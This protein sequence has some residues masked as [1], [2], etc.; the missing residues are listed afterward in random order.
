[1]NYNNI[2]TKTIGLRIPIEVHKQAKSMAS[3]MEISLTEFIDCAIRDYI[4]TCKMG[5]EA[6][7][8]EGVA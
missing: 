6:L 8:R 4:E 2:E 3:K 7:K 5:C 1:M